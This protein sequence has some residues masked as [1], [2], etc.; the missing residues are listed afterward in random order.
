M[1]K[2]VIVDHSLRDLQGHHYE[3]S[4]SVAEAAKRAGYAPLILAHQQFNPG[5]K[6]E[7]MPIMPVFEVDWLNQPHGQEPPL[8][9]SLE[10]SA[11]NWWQEWAQTPQGAKLR[12]KLQG[13]RE[14]LALWWQKDREALKALPL[15]HLTVGLLKTLWGGLRFAGQVLWPET[16]S[17]GP[18]VVDSLPY[19]SF[20]QSLAEVLPSLGLTAQDQVFIHTLG[21][22]QLEELFVWLQGQAR[23][24]LPL[25]HI[26]LRRDPDEPLVVNAAGLG[27]AGC[28]QACYSSQLWPEKIRF[29][30]DTEELIRKH[31]ALSP[32]RLGQLPIPFRQEKLSLS[33]QRDPAQ[34]IHL[35]YLGDARSEKGYQHLPALVAHL[36]D[37]YLQPNKVRFTIQSNYNVQGGEPN[38][39][40]AKV[41]L[42]AYPQANVQL[43]EAPLT[44]G[45]YYQLLASADLVVL[46]YNPQCYQ[47][48]SGVL[49]EAL[50][51]G[52]PV[53][54]PAGSWLAQQVND[55]RARVYAHPGE[56]PQAVTSALDHL[57]ALTQA[58][59]AYAAP[60]RQQQ[61][62]DRLLQ[63]LLRPEP[64]PE[65][66]IPALLLVV[67]L[68]S[69]RELEPMLRHCGQ[70]G[71]RLFVL[72]YGPDSA[73]S[74]DKSRWNQSLKRLG[75]TYCHWLHFPSD[76]SLGQ[77]WFQDWQAWQQ[78]VLPK[79]WQALG[80]DLIW[81][82]NPLC[83]AGL[84]K[85]NLGPI[86][87]LVT[88]Q[89]LQSHHYAQQQQREISPQELAAEIATL[90][91]SQALLPTCPVLA[92]K[93]AELT[94]HPQIYSLRSS[95]QGNPAL[96]AKERAFVR[97][98]LSQVLGLLLQ[99][100]SLETE[101]LVEP[102]CLKLAVLYPWGDL[103]ERQSGASQRTGLM[104]DCLQ[105]QGFEVGVFSIG[106]RPAAWHNQVY[107]DYHRPQFEP[108]PLVQRVYQQAYQTWQAALQLE[109]HRPLNF[110]T[111]NAKPAETNHWLPWIYYSCRH[112]PHFQAW[113]TGIIAWADA[114]IL[115][116][117]FWGALVGP[118]C[119][120]QGRP[121]ILTAHDVLAKQLDA[122]SPLAPIAL[123]EELQ[124]LR[125]ANT[126]VT[127]SPLDQAFFADW[128]LT[129]V[130]IPMGIDYAQIQ[131]SALFDL[132][133]T[134]D[135]AIQRDWRKPFCLFVGSQHGPN[136]A[137]VERLKNWS[138]AGGLG[139]DVVVVGSCCSRQQQGNF[140]SLG[141]V[142]TEVLHW[143]YHQTFLVVVP[144]T[145][146]TGM[147]VKIIEAMAYGKVI[148]G[149]SIAFRG[150]PVTTGL[151]CLICDTLDDYPARIQQILSQP[152]A[153]H[154]LRQQAQQFA[155]GYDY[156]HLYRGYGDLILA[157]SAQPS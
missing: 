44:P 83:W 137:A 43:I 89:S 131:Q 39:L 99:E 66:R 91:R 151:N 27:L 98:R 26:L 142:S 119:Q 132:G 104:V 20:G 135:L 62:P 101:A 15:S 147:S 149:S 92:E 77:G 24:T 106:D 69:I 57:T 120:H 73:E 154:S 115:E 134:P 130:C 127:L 124:A 128:G 86:P 38:I 36:W 21:I 148:L 81:L 76:C 51:A 111:D 88:L 54:V 150:Y 28:L 157:L 82:D 6:V 112:D 22:E 93:L 75:V 74:I 33:P 144:L 5:L 16:H 146:G 94:G 40:A 29:Y 109:P 90:Q 118:I 110:A 34:P 85:E 45:E 48:T 129:S 123:Y 100:R 107:F 35:V 114:V 52:K 61:S 58:A 121:L 141:P 56:L 53:V 102:T 136:L 139:W 156:R 126:V 32:L 47:R 9:V 72:V 67:M 7:L 140:Y 8:S 117:P 12:E 105:K 10:T 59:Q 79:N 133:L 19:R 108:A 143:L 55:R 103:P 46:P 145:A 41:S 65:S 64:E 14:R 70:R 11:L 78:V 80:P 113:L 30:S 3:C 95:L 17:S 68:A 1:H 63:I 155:Q 96:Q 138:P 87:V 18:V 2:F 13:S 31:A 42:A 71:Y 116:Y 122:T 153:Y 97:Q 23:A 50:A 84:E 152:E 37:D 125:Q 60:W 4:L 49:T 25:F